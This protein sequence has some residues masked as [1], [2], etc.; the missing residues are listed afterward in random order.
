[1][2]PFQPAK[3]RV[4]FPKIASS[5]SLPA[6]PH[7]RKITSPA[8][9]QNLQQTS[10]RTEASLRSDTAMTRASTP[11]ARAHMPCVGNTAESSTVLTSM[12]GMSLLRRTRANN[13]ARAHMYLT[14]RLL[15]NAPCLNSK[16]RSALRRI[17]L[18]SHAR[19]QPNGLRPLSSP[20]IIAP[21]H[22]FRQTDLPNKEKI[23]FNLKL[24]HEN[25]RRYMPD[26]PPYPIPCLPRT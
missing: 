25:T 2:R 23:T 19:R 14:C 5:V 7:G 6:P 9:K 1:M 11:S 16:L 22:H 10:Q 20:Y 21:K 13:L 3:K 18:L 26:D 24:Q 8:P 15:E 17:H 12:H 4:G